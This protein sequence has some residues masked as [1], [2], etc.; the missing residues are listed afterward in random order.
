MKLTT[1]QSE[2][3]LLKEYQRLVQVFKQVNLDMPQPSTST[4]DSLTVLLARLLVHVVQEQEEASELE[5][6]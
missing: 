5:E 2:D 1:L 3:L 4:I 6:V